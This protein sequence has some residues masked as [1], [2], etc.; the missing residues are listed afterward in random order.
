MFLHALVCCMCVWVWVIFVKYTIWLQ[1]LLMLSACVCVC[2]CICSEVCMC[3]LELLFLLLQCKPLC[4]ICRLLVWFSLMERKTNIS[5]KLTFVYI[6]FVWLIPIWSLSRVVSGRFVEFLFFFFPAIFQLTS[7]IW[8]S[9][10]SVELCCGYLQVRSY[11]DQCIKRSALNIF[12][13]RCGL[14]IQNGDFW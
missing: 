11:S 9:V 1:A 7:W 4:N 13:S 14:Q 2:V 3:D 5:H 8:L 10:W 6:L 12:W